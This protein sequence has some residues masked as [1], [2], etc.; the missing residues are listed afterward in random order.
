ME[1]IGS[2]IIAIIAAILFVLAVAVTVPVAIYV[3][4]KIN[5]FLN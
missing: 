5:D 1:N 3:S 2:L 4:R